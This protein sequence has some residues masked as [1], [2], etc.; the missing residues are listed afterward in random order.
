MR[1]KKIYAHTGYA[2]KNLMQPLFWAGRNLPILASRGLGVVLEP[3]P[4]TG[5]KRCRL[6]LTVLHVRENIFGFYSNLRLFF[7]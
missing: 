7:V 4:T 3:I 6:C 1:V 2:L 5:K